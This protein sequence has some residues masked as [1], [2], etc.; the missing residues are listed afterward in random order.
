M[1]SETWREVLHAYLGG[2]IRNLDGTP[3]AI[4]GT[5]DHVHLLMGLKATACLADVVRDLKANSSRWVHDEC[6]VGKFGWQE[7]YGAFT[8]SSS[9]L[10]VVREYISKQEEHHRKRSF[11][12]EYVELLKRCG[13]EYDGRFLW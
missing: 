6:G 5:A 2:L 3:V 9:Q 7:G 4:G 10:P 8:V 1:I 11:E 13:V 12:E